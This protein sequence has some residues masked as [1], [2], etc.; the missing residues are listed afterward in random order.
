M[1]ILGTRNYDCEIFS[2]CVRMLKCHYCWV[3]SDPVLSFH[4]D[5]ILKYLEVLSPSPSFDE[6]ISETLVAYVC[7]EDDK[8]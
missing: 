8:N 7:N 4:L 6:D 2:D 5:T 3:D 1:Q